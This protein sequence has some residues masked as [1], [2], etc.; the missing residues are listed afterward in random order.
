M[1]QDSGTSKSAAFAESVKDWQDRLLQL[2]RGNNLLYFKPGTTAVRIVD[3]SPDGIVEQLLSSRTGLTFDYAEPRSRRPS[4]DIQP[5]SN[6]DED[7]DT[8]PYVIPG[9]LRGD[10][11]L[12]ELQ[13]RLGNLRRRDREWEEEQGLNVLYLALGF[14][15]WIDEDGEPAK[16]PLLLLPCDLNRAS[17]RDPFTLSQDEDDLTTNSTLAVQMRKLG[18]ELPDSEIEI[19]TVDNYL[20]QVRQLTTSRPDW[21]VTDE[22]H[23]A[24]FAY[25]KLAMWRDLETIRENGT[26]HPVV[27]TLAG[28]EPRA[29]HDATPS[30][31]YSS[32]SQDLSGGRLDDVLDVRD[33]FAILPADY[34][35]LLAINSAR[36]GT[37]LVIH[38][39][40]GTGKSQT[41]AN[42]I[43]TFMAEGKS[44]LFFA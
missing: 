2:D 5:P 38:G 3:Q 10:C 31:L 19:D 25:S 6:Q 7:E 17:P 11:A 9:D 14:L 39:P 43:A 30:A 12:I 24:T 23:L 20:E 35:Q 8:E 32:M 15:E 41:I 37:N 36:A 16:S 44:V 33:Q 4:V 1:S 13:R 27:N 34:S 26:D 42:M 40:P 18:I 28:A 22:I 29:E 21:S